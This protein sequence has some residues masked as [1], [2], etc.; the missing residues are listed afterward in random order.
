MIRLLMFLLGKDY[1]PC[2]SCQTLKDQLELSN[3]ENQRLTDTLLNILQPK[4][5]EAPVHEIPNLK[6]PA[7]TFTRRRAEL[8]QQDKIKA[9]AM[10]SPL[11]AVPDDKLKN[12]VKPKEDTKLENKPQTLEELEEELGVTSEQ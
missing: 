9:A 12:M 11:A 8:E 4:I 1:E 5:Q 10:K 6:R 2:K 7:L 3:M